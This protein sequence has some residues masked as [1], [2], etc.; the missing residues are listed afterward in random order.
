[1]NISFIGLGKMGNQMVFRLMAD[2]HELRVFDVDAT[3]V[4]R[5]AGQGAIAARD[6]KDLIQR[7]EKTYVWLMIP[8]N[9]VDQEIDRLLAILPAGSVI[10][11]GGNSDFRLTLQRAKRC[12]AKQI[13]LID[14]GT[15]GGVLGMEKGFS[16]MVGGSE[17]T[18]NDLTSVFKSLA[19]PNGWHYFGPTGTGHYIKMV[20]N[21]I[22]YGLMEAYAEGYRILQDGPIKDIDLAAVGKVWQN[23]SI[24]GSL[25]N[26]CAVQALSENPNMDGVDGFVAES[27]EARWTLEVAH[28]AAIETPVIQAAM[29]VRLASQSGTRNFATKLLAEMRNKFGGHAVN[30]V[31][32]DKIQTNV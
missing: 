21:G 7:D 25:L 16:M 19:Q 8:A 17:T 26:D 15:S 13:E 12:Q 2:G 10:I 31:A 4:Q 23:G 27:G 11:D 14:V 32:P 5:V 24:I 6:R 20:H 3:A 30:K 1:M 29:D 9:Y 22:E 18:V 28:E